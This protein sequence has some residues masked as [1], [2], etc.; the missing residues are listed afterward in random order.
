MRASNRHKSDPLVSYRQA[1]RDSLCAEYVNRAHTLE[2]EI[3]EMAK[4]IEK[5]KGRMAELAVMVE[6]LKDAQ[7]KV[8]AVPPSP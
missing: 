4:D 5:K 2:K 8:S 6:V 3:E 1:F 7:K